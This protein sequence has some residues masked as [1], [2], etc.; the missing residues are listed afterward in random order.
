[1][2]IIAHWKK[3][4]IGTFKKLDAQSCYDE[5]RS[6]GTAHSSSFE[7]VSNQEVVDFARN[8]PKSELHKAFEWDDKKA[9]EIYRRATAKDLK[10]HL[11]TYKLENPQ[12]S[13]SQLQTAV[14][15]PLF[16]N[17]GCKDLNNHAPTEIVLS[18]PTLRQATVNK[19]LSELRSWQNRYSYLD[20]LKQ[21]FDAI[22]QI[23]IP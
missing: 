7:D 13:S 1:M 14:E 3:D 18:Q 2:A 20:E 10:N 11:Y 9:A 4:T 12:V 15:I 21:V 6:I 17:P 16:L 5:I 22:S 19:A 23:S 8:N